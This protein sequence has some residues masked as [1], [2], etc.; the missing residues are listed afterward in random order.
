MLWLGV[1]C[2][3]LLVCCTLI[4]MI[5]SRLVCVCVCACMVVRDYY[6][7]KRA[8]LTVTHGLWWFLCVSD[9]DGRWMCLLD[10]YGLCVLCFFF[11]FSVI[12]VVGKQ[13]YIIIKERWRWCPPV[14]MIL[15][16]VSLL[17]RRLASAIK[18]GQSYFHLLQ[19]E[20]REEQEA[21]ERRRM[22]RE[23]QLRTEPRPPSFSSD[24]D[25]DSEGWGNNSHQLSFMLSH[26][27]SRWHNLSA[28]M[29]AVCSV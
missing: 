21:E 16:R 23:E 14:F 29:Q 1:I 13:T 27:F 28:W 2:A 26:G 19:K 11:F 12:C 8:L 5:Y 20:E 18:R 17:C 4:W 22:R 10:I 25:S 6:N 15:A 24:S 7:D 3:C 9:K